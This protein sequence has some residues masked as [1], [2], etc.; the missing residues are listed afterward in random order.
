[1]RVL[2]ISLL[3]GVYSSGISTRRTALSLSSEG[4]EVVAVAGEIAPG[5]GGER[6]ALISSFP[7]RPSRLFQLVGDLIGCDVDYFAWERRA[8]AYCLNLLETQHIDVIYGRGSPVSG[9]VVAQQV[10]R[11]SGIPFVAHFADPIPATPDWMPNARRRSKMVKTVVPIL[12]QASLV[13]FVSDEMLR[14]QED[15]TGVAL[16][17]KAMIIPNPVPSL[18][19]GPTPPIESDFRFVFVGSL[20]GGR[21]GRSLFEG[22]AILAA[23]GLRF[24]VE[25]YGS[26]TPEIKAR[27]MSDANL[28][29]YVSF[30]GWTDKVP[31]VLA[32]AHC[33]VDIDSDSQYPVYQSNKVME[34]LGVDRMILAITPTGSATE[35]LLKSLTATTLVVPHQAGLIAQAMEWIMSYASTPIDFHERAAVRSDFSATA[36]AKRLAHT[37]EGLVRAG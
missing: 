16:A 34:Y 28:R 23:R 31:A 17:E 4:Q 13:T 22:I 35:G 11:I 7:S 25:F 14:Y 5:A 1:M 24:G 10:S 2:L 12:R 33:L 3:Y 32:S 6:V 18:S 29:G 20:F 9:L 27:V 37:M 21:D 15:V 36:I 30:R 8:V 19:V 26:V